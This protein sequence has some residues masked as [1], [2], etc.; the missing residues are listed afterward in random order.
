MFTYVTTKTF[1]I[2]YKYFGSNT[3][4]YILLNRNTVS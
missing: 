1:F 3:N 4:K 2:E